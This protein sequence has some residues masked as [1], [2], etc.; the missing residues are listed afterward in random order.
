MWSAITQRF[1][2]QIGRASDFRYR[3]INV[4]NRSMSQYKVNVLQHRSN[5]LHTDTG[6]YIRLRQRF[7]VPSAWRL[8][9]MKTM[10][11]ISM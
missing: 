1:I 4:R 2:A 9:C 7:I 6:I 5:T 8:N 10:F 11:Q 3:W